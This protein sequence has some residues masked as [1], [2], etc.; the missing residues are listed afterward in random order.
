LL[1][2]QDHGYGGSHEKKKLVHVTPLYTLLEKY[3]QHLAVKGF[4]TNTLRV[5]RVHLTLFLN[6]C[7]KRDA[8]T[9]RQITRALVE[10][11]QQHLFYHRKNSG[12]PLAPSTRYSRLAQLKVWLKWMARQNHIL[13][14]PASDL[15]LPLL[16]Y[17]LP[18]VLNKD[19]AERVLQQPDVAKMAGLRDRA[20]LEMLYSTGMR[21]AELL[22]LRLY[23]LDPN[24]GV[25]T[26]R[27]GKGRRD[28][29]V[30]VGE[31]ALTWVER[32]FAEVRP[33]L[34]SPVEETAF[35]TLNGKP[36]SPNYLSW[37]VRRYVQGAEIT[38]T[39]A[40][41]I[42]RHTMATLMLEGGADI[43]YI[44]AM[45]GHKRLDTTQIYTHVSIRM[46]QQVHAATHPAARLSP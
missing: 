14:D 27:Q 24:R 6:W 13:C 11:Y 4:T 35:L 22:N 43:R 37:V 40:C 32:Y 9:S 17:Q 42:F 28:R 21:R 25:V 15:E 2:W 38:K 8:T 20:I 19:E 36:I 44:Q 3:L 26:V 18:S 7:R 29:V 10:C 41:H 45:L 30:P 16:S 12:E 5:R 46:L 31:R 33:A 39:G 23:D 34:A 1:G